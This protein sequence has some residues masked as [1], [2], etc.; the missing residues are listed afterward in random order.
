[1]RRSGKI[2]LVCY[3]MQSWSWN[4]WPA[5]G[6]ARIKPE[7]E[8]RIHRQFFPAPERSAR[9][10]L[11]FV[12]CLERCK[13]AREPPHLRVVERQCHLSRDR[14]YVAIGKTTAHPSCFATATAS[15]MTCSIT[16]VHVRGSRQFVRSILADNK[17]WHLR[18]KLGLQQVVKVFRYRVWSR[19]TLPTQP[20]PA[21]SA[22]LH[23][24]NVA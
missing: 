14:P 4:A 7:L 5:Q 3:R 6:L 18:R 16:S 23:R 8:A 13:I 20:V 19:F 24:T 22:T 17:P 2:K 1:M 11:T 12:R 15:A 10:C 9:R 21:C